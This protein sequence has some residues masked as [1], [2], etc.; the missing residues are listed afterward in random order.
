MPDLALRD[1]HRRYPGETPIDALRGVTLNV[2]QGEFVA[3][4]GPSG[5][6]K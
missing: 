5:G 3:I 6:G 2:L 1:V 4:E